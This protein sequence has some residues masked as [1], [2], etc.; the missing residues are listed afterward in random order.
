MFAKTI[1]LSDAFGGEFVPFTERYPDVK[2]PK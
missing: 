1:V 2:K